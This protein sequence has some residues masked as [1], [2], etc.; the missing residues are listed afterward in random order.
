MTTGASTSS[1]NDSRNKV[2]SI[3]DGSTIT[4]KPNICGSGEECFISGNDYGTCETSIPREL[5]K[6]LYPGERCRGDEVFGTCMFGTKICNANN[7]CEGVTFYGECKSTLDCNNGAY[8]NEDGVCLEIVAES[9]QCTTHDSC[10]D[11]LMCFYYTPE[12]AYGRCTKV[13]SREERELVRPEYNDEPVAQANMERL[14]YTGMVNETT[15]RCASLLKSTN[16]GQT[17]TTDSDCPTSDDNI[18]A[19]CKCG[20]N[21]GGL[22]YCDIEADDDE[23]AEAT[24]LFKNYFGD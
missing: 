2:C 21:T 5:D 15:G 9:E 6:F 1:G 11:N 18:F 17:C 24:Q 4:F 7:R 16:K 14:C 23:W 13:G 20:Y 3:D 12:Q 22:K 8:C 19:Q 10:D